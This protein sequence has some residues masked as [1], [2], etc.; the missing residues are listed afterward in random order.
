MRRMYLVCVSVIWGAFRACVFRTHIHAQIDDKVRRIAVLDLDGRCVS[1][2]FGLKAADCLTAR[3]PLLCCIACISA[4]ASM[5]LQ[6]RVRV[7]YS[8]MRVRSKCINEMHTPAHTPHTYQPGRCAR[9]GSPTAG[10]ITYVLASRLE[11][12]QKE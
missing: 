11:R 5:Y 4:C 12:V 6:C 10:T 7:Q 3:S 1:V 8:F 9:R 2:Y